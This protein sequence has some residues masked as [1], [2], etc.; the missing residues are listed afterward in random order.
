MDGRPIKLGLLADTPESLAALS[1]T[2]NEGA[3]ELISSCLIGAGRFS[4]ADAVDVWVLCLS[5][6][7]VDLESLLNDLNERELAYVVVDAGADLTA[8]SGLDLKINEAFNAQR[9]GYRARQKPKRVWVLAASTGGP[10]AISV[11]LRALGSNALNDAFIYAQHIEAHSLSAL[12][13]SVKASTA[14]DA[15]FCEDGVFVEA[16]HIYLVH[17][18]RA[19]SLTEAGRFVLSEQAWSGIYQPSINQIIAKV[20]RLY[21][22]NAG[23]L[24]FSGMGDDGAEACRIMKAV[25][26]LVM[27]QSFEGCT[28]DSMPRS[29]SGEI[30][31]AFSG[32]AEALAAKVAEYAEEIISE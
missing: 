8:N 2:I 7:C 5:A 30:E 19:F 3:H 31:V 28:V 12:M 9:H 25:G 11:F 20:A 15:R 27:I 14:L 32:S 24:V 26:G 17:P 22:R 1:A 29:V 21:R 23:A 18:L 4:F 16:G 13:T 6:D 10:K